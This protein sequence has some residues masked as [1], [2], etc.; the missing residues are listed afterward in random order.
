MTTFTMMGEKVSEKLRCMCDRWQIVEAKTGVYQGL[1][2][3]MTG[4]PLTDDEKASLKAVVEDNR[5]AGALVG[6]HF[7]E[8]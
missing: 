7:E 3:I 6:L 5:P 8:F 1:L 4:R 2:W